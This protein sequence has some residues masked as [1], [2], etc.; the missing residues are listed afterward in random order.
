MTGEG[1]LHRETLREALRVI[2]AVAT[3]EQARI[4]LARMLNDLDDLEAQGLPSDAAVGEAEK[5]LTVTLA[6][7]GLLPISW[8]TQ[9]GTTIQ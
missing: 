8:S 4:P 2:Q 7:T 3:L 1:D 9:N 5:P 6:P